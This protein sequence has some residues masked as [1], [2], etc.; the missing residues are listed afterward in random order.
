MSSLDFVILA[1]RL[2]ASLGREFSDNSPLHL[3]IFRIFR[4]LPPALSRF[5]ALK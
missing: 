2:G 5:T 1:A 3:F 4:Q